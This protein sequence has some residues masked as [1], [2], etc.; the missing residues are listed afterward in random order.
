[1]ALETECPGCFPRRSSRRGD[2]TRDRDK[3]ERS[4]DYDY[5]YNHIGKQQQ[6][7]YS[8]PACG[9]EQHG[10]ETVEGIQGLPAT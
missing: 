5:D 3:A 6:R 1:M 7:V 10:T 9:F 8:L 4:A 2:E